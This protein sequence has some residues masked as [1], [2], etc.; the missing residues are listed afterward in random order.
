M[1]KKTKNYDKTLTYGIYQIS[2]ELN[3]NY[4]DDLTQSIIYDYPELNGALNTLKEYVKHYYISEIV[5]FLFEY[6]LL[7]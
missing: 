3:T 6:E 7:K 5:P 1:A 4:K 2:V